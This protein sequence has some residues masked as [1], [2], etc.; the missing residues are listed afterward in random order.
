VTAG[1]TTRLLGTAVMIGRRGLNGGDGR[2]DSAVPWCGS[3]GVGGSRG[4]GSVVLTVEEEWDDT[5]PK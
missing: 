3:D 5:V 4:G 1:R 2:V